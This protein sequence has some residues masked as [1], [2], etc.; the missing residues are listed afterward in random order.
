[1]TAPVGISIDKALLDPTL[2]GAALGPADTWATWLAVLRA[3][4]GLPLDAGQWQ[5]FDSVSGGRPP[6]ANRVREFWA[7]VGRR[8]GKS[9]TAA[10]LAAFLAAFGQHKLSAGEVGYV[11]VMSPTR[12]QSSVIFGYVRGFFEQSP[13]LAQLVDTVTADEIRLRNNVTIQVVPANYRTVRG[14]TLLAVIADESAF[15]RDETSSQPDIEIYRACT[16]AL[17]ASGGMWVG[18]SSPYSQRGLL[19]A[20]HRAAFGKSDPLCLVVQG[21]TTAFNATIDLSIIAAADAED[22]EA[23]QAEWHGLFRG[24]LSSYVDRAVVEKCVDKGVS[25]RR[26]IA[27]VKYSAFVDVSG[28]QHD[29][30]VLAIGHRQG[31]AASLDAVLEIEA[32]F[33][34]PIAVE[35]CADLLARYGIT[36]VRGDAY[37]A[38]WTVSAFRQHGIRYDASTYN[39]SEIFLNFLPV[40]TGGSALLLDNPRLVSQL[41]QLERRTSRNGRDAVDHPRGGADDVANA[42]AGC[43]VHLPAVSGRASAFPHHHNPGFANGYSPQV[44]GGYEQVYRRAGRRRHA[45]TDMP[46]TMRDPSRTDFPVRGVS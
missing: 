31:G 25:E 16:P 33:D 22:S 3:A 35:R 32:P 39:R 36:S 30:F 14:R 7:I 21:P 44:L 1:M 10:A 42:V 5:L 12:A 24:D 13:V 38:E 45:T 40:L 46:R 28:G 18:I 9:R 37:A 15:W 8:S 34:P 20:K 4:F 6:P 11:V 23:A 27:T 26:P 29:S 41:C 43:L 2:L 17:A 19:Y